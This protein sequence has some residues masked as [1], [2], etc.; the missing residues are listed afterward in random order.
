MTGRI[1][2]RN[3]DIAIYATPYK[4]NGKELDEE[5]G[6]YYY[7]AR[8]LHPKYAMWLSTDPLEGTY[9]NVS[10]YTYCHDN[11]ILRIDKNGNAD[12]YSNINGKYLGSDNNPK[13][14]GDMRLIADLTFSQI[15]Y[16]NPNDY[17]Q[18]E[19]NSIIITFEND[20]IQSDLQ[21]I[22]DASYIDKLEHQVYLYLDRTTGI[23]SSHIGKNGSNSESIIE[24][25][26]APSQ[27]LNFLYTDE[28]PRN[29][30]L[31][32]QVHTHPTSIS[33][34]LTT[35]SQMSD[36]DKNV[37]ILLQI[38]IYG[39]DAMKGSGEIGFPAII[40]RVNPNGNMYRKVGKTIGK[41]N[42][43]VFNIGKD[44]LEIWGRSNNP[45]FE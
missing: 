38:P 3:K 34:G 42:K 6:L 22:R 9:P 16:N 35:L 39:I 23:V 21:S 31:I 18:F 27:G 37:A 36:K 44:A 33:E 5:T 17:L 20:K 41:N 14:Q 8:Y 29:K 24:S 26:P 12:Y 11:P 43:S 13:T 2:Q 19:S 30:I 1:K 7:G 45:I 32:G 25:Y 15:Q 40:N 4:F 10:S 28:R